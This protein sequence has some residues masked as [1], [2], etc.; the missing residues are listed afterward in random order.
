MADF[1]SV[2][3]QRKEK[4][5]EGGIT[6]SFPVLLQAKWGHVEVCETSRM[7]DARRI[8]REL[9][10]FLGIAQ[11]HWDTQYRNPT[12]TIARDLRRRQLRL[13]ASCLHLP[14]IKTGIFHDGSQLIL[15]RKPRGR[16]LR[17]IGAAMGLMG[18]FFMLCPALGPPFNGRKDAF[19][20]PI[21]IGLVQV[22]A[23]E[24]ILFF[25]RGTTSRPGQG[26]QLLVTYPV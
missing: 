16:M 11:S 17:L 25:R 6:V 4:S 9:G 5:D 20:E 21:V 2:V 13:L 14:N 26:D 3:W 12:S 22:V 18:V 23:A 8:T 15:S 1:E 7:D 19:W 24:V 10:E